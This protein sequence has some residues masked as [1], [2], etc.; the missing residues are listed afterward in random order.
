MRPYMWDRL[1]HINISK[2]KTHIHYVKHKKIKHS[3]RLLCHR[4]I[5]KV[6]REIYHCTCTN[7]E[8]LIMPKHCPFQLAIDLIDKTQSMQNYYL[9]KL[10]VYE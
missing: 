8:L 4:R 5:Y 2:N 6:N 9:F 7:Y 3:H 10:F 1:K